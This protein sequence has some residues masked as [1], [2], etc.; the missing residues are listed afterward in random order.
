LSGIIFSS[1]LM[2]FTHSLAIGTM[3][4]AVEKTGNNS[5]WE[6][7]EDSQG[8]TVSERWTSDKSLPAFRGRTTIDASVWDILAILQDT[9]R[10]K[11]W[12]HKC[13]ESYQLENPGPTEYVIYNR[14]DSPW[15]FSDRD[16]V[17]ASNV[18]FKPERQ[19]VVIDIQSVVR[20]EEPPRD[21]VVRMP[22]LKGHYRFKLV[23][24]SKTWV[25]YQIDADPGGLLPSWLARLAS[26][27]LPFR[28]LEGL[29]DRLEWANENGNYRK[30]AKSFRE[31]YEKRYR[32]RVEEVANAIHSAP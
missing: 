29:R 19:E 32:G 17:V 15:P 25:E 4:A 7:I 10:S 26:R 16:V 11:E 2:V 3:P 20:S 5:Q 27:D 6:M 1:A 30:I 31:M 13:V 18:I 28:T 14:V 12:V 21:G 24:P 9:P 22:N 8:I 23:S